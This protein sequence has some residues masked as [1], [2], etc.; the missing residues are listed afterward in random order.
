[1]R[2]TTWITAFTFYSCATSE[3]FLPPA[4]SPDA[5][6]PTCAD[7]WI[8]L[9][10]ERDLKHNFLLLYYQFPHP[11]VWMLGPTDMTSALG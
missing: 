7:W 1:M 3:I 10:R 9:E 2:A 8:V 6:L 5:K 11:A 4:F